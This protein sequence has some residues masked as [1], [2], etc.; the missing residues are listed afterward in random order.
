MTRRPPDLVSVTSSPDGGLTV[1]WA[2][3][4]FYPDSE[5]GEKVLVSLDGALHQTLDGDETS[6]DVAKELLEALGTHLLTIGIAYWWSG[7]PP[8]E[9]ATAVQVP[10]YGG[11]GGGGVY[12]AAKPVVTVEAV[13]ARTPHAP[14]S[15]TIRWKSNNYNDGRIL[16]GPQSAPRQASSSIRPR[17]EVYEGTW[18][19]DQPLQPATLYSF[20][21]SVRNTLHSPGWIETTV[22]V[23]TPPNRLS[24]RDFLIA[25]GLP[26]VTGVRA[27]MGA[28]RSVRRWLTGA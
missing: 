8:E 1:T 9:Q 4:T 16:W 12:P 2:L 27:A 3:D 18:T 17:G 13:R 28:E 11:T 26:P 5:P 21:V 22:V 14:S 15:V 6:A 25:G 23:R 24:V 7:D 20:T 19:T 10:L